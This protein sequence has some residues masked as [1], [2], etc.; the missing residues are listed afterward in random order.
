M[1]ASSDRLFEGVERLIT[2]L[3]RVL[4]WQRIRRGVLL[5]LMVCC[6][7]PPSAWGQEAA[8]AVDA[9]SVRAEQEGGQTRL[10]IYLKV[11]YTSLRFLSTSEGFTARYEAT[12]KIYTLDDDDQPDHL[13][14]MR[15]WS[16][17]ATVEH[18]DATQ[19]EQVY[20]P[21]T[22]SLKLSPGHYFVD[23]QVEDQSSGETYTQ[24]RQ[25]HVRSLRGAVAVSDLLLLDE[26]EE[27]SNTIYPSVTGQVG[28]ERARLQFFYELYARQPQQ[29]E[30]T[31]TIMRLKEK[32]QFSPVRKLLGLAEEEQGK[33]VFAGTETK[34]VPAGRMQAV[35]EV[36]MDSLQAGSYVANVVVKD[37]RGRQLA[38]VSESF[39]VRW[40][41]LDQHIRQLN[42]AIAQLQYI[43]KEE[44]IE[45]I[46]KPRSR[47]EQ[48][49]RFR[50]FWDKRDPTPS[51]G[52][53]E[54]MEEYYYRVSLA[55]RKFGR[56][57]D[58]W[59]TDRG[60]VQVLFGEPDYIERHAYDAK[61]DPY[62]VWYY[63][64]IGRRFIFVDESGG[65][66]YDLMVP[67]WDARTRIR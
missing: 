46:T 16:Q 61:S 43:A 65:G 25:V 63:Y 15:R 40:A 54:R 36:P 53:N 6:L 47:R 8:F 57:M 7:T 58:G 35:A 18:F 27:E 17:S 33:E 13:V 48:L 24:E 50:R 32:G 51:T 55:N 9:M 52:R 66:D 14:Q 62:Q 44:E 38:V 42:S 30:V 20:D 56:L 64:R 22:Q 60:H 19:A 41:G 45:H 21:T 1:E 2:N 11:P 29:L 67:I 59:K 26:Y 12:V 3:G 31:R 34:Q 5:V 10:D 4:S 49:R 39:S 37:Q 28:T 23:L